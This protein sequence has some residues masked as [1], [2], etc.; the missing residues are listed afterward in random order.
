[1]VATLVLA[2]PVLAAHPAP[3]AT[4]M[5]IQTQH[6][7]PAREV[8][9]AAPLRSPRAVVTDHDSGQVILVPYAGFGW[10]FGPFWD[11]YWTSNYWRFYDRWPDR[12]GYLLQPAVPD[13]QALVTLE[14]DP[15]RA[16]VAVD[17]RDVGKASLFRSVHH[18]LWLKAG[19]HVI[20]IK[21]NGYQTLRFDFDLE[22]GRAYTLSYGMN[23]GTGVDT[24]SS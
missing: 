11:P 17:G 10:G 24:R 22:S 19:K 15:S 13:G 18:P 12:A 8:S 21:R 5:P 1:M 23:K 6:V 16:E 14:I 2:T 7:M 9:G 3:R 4:L 20:E